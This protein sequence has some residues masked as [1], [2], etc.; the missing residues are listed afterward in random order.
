MIY[1]PNAAR[2]LH[3]RVQ[4]STIVCC[5]LVNLGE[6]AVVNVNAFSPMSFGLV[7]CRILSSGNSLVAIMENMM[8][9]NGIGTCRRT[10]TTCG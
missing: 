2:D 5:R 8:V 10:N 7:I 3:E 6:R 4:R 1:P 9:V